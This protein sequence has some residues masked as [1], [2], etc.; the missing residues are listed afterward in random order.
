LGCFPPNHSRPN[1]RIS[2][3][4]T[5]PARTR[6]I[7]NANAVKRRVFGGQSA[8][9]SLQIFAEQEAHE[10]YIKTMRGVVIL[11]VPHRSIHALA[12]SQNTRNGTLKKARK[13]V[14]A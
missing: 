11:D 8:R 7:K 2:T 9:G 14:A 13:A 4:H 1:N 5:Y 3:D 10:R 12:L 6:Q